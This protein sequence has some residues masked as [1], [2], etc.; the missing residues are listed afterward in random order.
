MLKWKGFT[1]WQFLQGFSLENRDIRF[2]LEYEGSIFK[3][4]LKRSESIRADA[5]NRS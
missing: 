2:N 3:L 5:S 4:H 1:W